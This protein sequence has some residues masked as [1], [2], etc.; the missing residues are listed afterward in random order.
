M[1]LNHC[2]MGLKFPGKLVN[3]TSWLNISIMS[4]MHH[5]SQLE[6]ACIYINSTGAT[7]YP[8]VQSHTLLFP[9]REFSR[10]GY[11]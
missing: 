3:S 7:R 9:Y 1:G 4:R 6:S 10:K 11:I 5:E 8:F 2:Y